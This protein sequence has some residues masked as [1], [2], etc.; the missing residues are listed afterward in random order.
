MGP[1]KTRSMRGADTF[2]TENVRETTGEKLRLLLDPMR[3]PED[4]P[5]LPG[6]LSHQSGLADQASP[7]TDETDSIGSEEPSACSQHLKPADG[8]TLW[9]S[10][11]LPTA[12]A[13][14]C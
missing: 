14:R 12:A 13:L 7:I 8:I 2:Q 4:I 5:V 11:A 1:P 9:A 10:A 3:L 6:P